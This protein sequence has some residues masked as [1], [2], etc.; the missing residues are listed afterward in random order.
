[1]LLLVLKLL[2]S[3]ADGVA[4]AGQFLV[5]ELVVVMVGVAADAVDVVVAH[6]HVDVV[7]R[8]LENER[9]VIQ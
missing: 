2:L 4:A 5:V 7:V 8:E 1:M 9:I 6:V 3:V